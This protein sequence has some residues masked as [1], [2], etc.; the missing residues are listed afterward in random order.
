M[1]PPSGPA[2]TLKPGD[3]APPFPASLK[4]VR[5]NKPSIPGRPAIV[6]AWASWC[7]PCKVA[8]PHL[9]KLWDAY[10]DKIDFV[11]V[12]VFERSPE[13]AVDWVENG[14][15]ETMRYPVALED[16]DADADD[17]T[18]FADTWMRPAGQRGIP[19][20]FAI[21]AAGKIVWIGHP[22]ALCEEMLDE[23]VAGTL[24]AEEAMAKY[25]MEEFKKKM[26]AQ[27]AAKAAAA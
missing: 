3:A 17:G 22:V 27:K 21:D 1:A 12:N 13:A 25:S 15:K 24:T 18:G 5:G 11:G 9:S 8:M 7:F 16:E 19:A 6:E 2:P 4:M 20:A 14:G 10:G 23:L 26:E